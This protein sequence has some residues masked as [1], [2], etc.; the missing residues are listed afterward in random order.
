MDWAPP[1]P[2]RY[3]CDLRKAGPWRLTDSW[4]RETSQKRVWLAF[5][6]YCFPPLCLTS[7]GA[8]LRI[9]KYRASGDFARNQ[10]KEITYEGPILVYPF[11]REH[12]KGRGPTPEGAWT[13]IDVVAAALGGEWL[14]ALDVGEGVLEDSPYPKGFVYVATCGATG[15]V[16][17]IFTRGKEKEQADTIRKQFDGMRQFV[18]YNRA[19][20]DEYDAFARDLVKALKERAAAAPADG[21]MRRAVADLE[22]LLQYIP[23]QFEANRE[24]IKTP[25]HCEGLAAQIV[26]LVDSPAE[27]RADVVKGLGKAIRTIGGAQDDMLAAFR[28]ALKVARQRAAQ[29]HAAAADPAVREAMRDVRARTQTILRV[30]SPYEGH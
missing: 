29:V 23:D 8:F 12:D 25:E 21:E 18:R 16:E 2:A 5:L 26:A 1:F 13:V 17:K 4:R 11:A 9:P 10:A 24:T 20:L 7:D 14:K 22:P 30:R 19:R 3:R 6:N 27:G 28:M 15:E